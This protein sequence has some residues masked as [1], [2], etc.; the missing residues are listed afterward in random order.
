MWWEVLPPNSKDTKT[1]ASGLSVPDDVVVGSIFVL[2]ENPLRSYILDRE[3]EV[4]QKT[5]LSRKRFVGGAPFVG[6]PRV[7][8][9]YYEWD[10]YVSD[11]WSRY[12]TR[13]AR[14]VWK[15]NF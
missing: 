3:H 13:E 7:E 8:S 4:V 15:R 10:G 12:I 1:E 14:L 5:R 6:D 11:D 2:D 9:A